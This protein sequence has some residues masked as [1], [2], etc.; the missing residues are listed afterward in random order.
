MDSDAARQWERD[1]VAARASTET[2]EFWQNYGAHTGLVCARFHM[3]CGNREL[4]GESDGLLRSAAAGDP[5][6]LTTLFE[7]H[8]DRLR[9]MIRLRLDG[10]IRA[11][12]DES[13][14]IQEAFIEAAR[15]LGDYVQQPPLPFF[16][17]LRQIAGHKLIDLQR[18]HLGAAR[19][20][21][22]REF[23]LQQGPLPAATSASL[24]AQ[25]LGRLTSPSQAAIKAETRLRVQE[26]LNAM[27]P[28]DREVLA[29]RH[30]ERLSNQEAAQVLEIDPS[31]CSNRYVRAL[32]RLRKTLEQIPGF[33]E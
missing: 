25:L 15:R 7:H 27:D 2:P 11:R 33:T 19:R 24:A 31:A 4:T 21:A 12:V 16:L 22:V 28:I 23:S 8:R 5:A 3:S 32:A 30:F 10:R 13:D 14:V 9:R 1:G 18:K 17:W 26:A 20:T 29:L 6:A